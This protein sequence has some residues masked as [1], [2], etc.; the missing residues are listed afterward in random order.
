MRGWR[1]LSG[2]Q[3]LRGAGGHPAGGQGDRERGEE[4]RDRG[5]PQVP[6]LQQEGQESLL[7]RS[8]DR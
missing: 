7:R 4:E 2:S 1:D 8:S 5:V 3:E 6:G